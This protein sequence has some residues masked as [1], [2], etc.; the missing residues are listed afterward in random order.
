[1]ELRKK[2]KDISLIYPLITIMVLS[3]FELPFLNTIGIFNIGY[4]VGKL[5]CCFSFALILM[6]KKEFKAKKY[7]IVFILYE[8]LL[9]FTSLYLGLPMVYV[10]TRVATEI[11]FIIFVD[12]F[13][14]YYFKEV[15]NV[16]F[17]F[18]L[19][20][21]IINFMLMLKYK[22]GIYNIGESSRTY[23]L[24]GHVNNMP[25]YIFPAIFISFTK[26]RNGNKFTKVL[27][28]I[29]L[30][31]SI[32]SV[33]Y[34][35]SA[36]STIGLLIIVFHLIVKDF[37]IN[38]MHYYLISLAI[39]ILI[40]V[41]GREYKLMSFVSMLFNRNIT[42]TG[43]TNIWNNTL[44]Y[45]KQKPFLGYGLETPLMTMTKFNF[46]TPH[47]RYLYILYTGGVLGFTLFTYFVFKIWRISV[48]KYKNHSNDIVYRSLY[49]TCCAVFIIFQM[50]TY[51]GVLIYFPFIL[52]ANIRS[53]DIT[54]KQMKGFDYEK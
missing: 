45:I 13:L 47:N 42:F 44:Y 52:L 49:Y 15:I 10:I 7:I 28:I 39:F 16:V 8:F 20:I 4:K 14:E 38:L 6:T 35:N 25:V 32:I 3:Y 51:V 31:I 43:R 24:L 41:I 50:E 1:M 34:G 12:Y 19:I 29:L 53:G 46:I 2:N 36:T 48:N 18:L 23:W 9:L 37:K 22:Y 30:S 27:S 21:I 11:T 33:V 40:V 26:Y 5:L 54:V 17:V